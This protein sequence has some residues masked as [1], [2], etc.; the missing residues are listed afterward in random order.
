MSHAFLIGNVL[1]DDI[2]KDLTKVIKN[3]LLNID[4]L[5]LKENPDIYY[6]N[7]YESLITKDNIKELLNN[8]SKTSQFNNVKIYIINGAEKMSSSVYNSIL[9]TLEEPEKNIYAFLI[10]KN[11]EMVGD[12]I[13]SRC[14]KIYL[15]FDNETTYD[16]ELIKTTNEI[17]KY[18]ETNNINTIAYNSKIY[19][20]ISDRIMFQNI[21]KIMLDEYNKSLKM[22]LNNNE[23]I[24]E[25][26]EI[27]K[28]NDIISM[29]KKILT[30]D[31]FINLLNSY[32]NKNSTIDRFIIEMW[33]C[34]E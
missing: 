10:T 6:F 18:I 16:D 28:N 32:L 29:S 33:R 27:I 1:F 14:Q 22:M 9:K 26:N 25:N 3:K 12:T 7:Q 21:L 34:K 13:K 20:I 24:K 19:S 17:I 23:T 2:E 31:K 15:N 11:M 30:I 4:N 8:L 5:N